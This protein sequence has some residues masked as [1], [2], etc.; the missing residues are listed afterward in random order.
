LTEPAVPPHEVAPDVPV[1]LSLLIA[2]AL[3]KNPAERPRSAAEMYEELARVAEGAP[4][5]A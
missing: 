4:A 3:A 1:A 2:R 5:A